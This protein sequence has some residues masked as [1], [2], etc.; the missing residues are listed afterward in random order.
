MTIC[1][2]CEFEPI[3]SSV[4]GSKSKFQWHF[5]AILTL[6]ILKHQV[7]HVRDAQQP[8]ARCHGA[9]GQHA[10]PPVWFRSRYSR[11]HRGR[12]PHGDAEGPCK[13]KLLQISSTTVQQLSN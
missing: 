8:D 5:I 9:A 1:N 6:V 13:Q 2:F 10:Q 12:L 7:W 11:G 3:I 4:I